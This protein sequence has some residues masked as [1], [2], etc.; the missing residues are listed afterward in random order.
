[1]VV[2]VLTKESYY[3]VFAVLCVFRHFIDFN[4]HKDIFFSLMNL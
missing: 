3:K 4:A 1:M 2:I